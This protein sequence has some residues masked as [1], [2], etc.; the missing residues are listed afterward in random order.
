MEDPGVDP[1]GRVDE[2]RTVRGDLVAKK[3]VLRD[4]FI[5][6]FPELTFFFGG[7]PA[8]TDGPE[9]IRGP[10]QR[11][12]ETRSGDQNNKRKK[13]KRQVSVLENL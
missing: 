10:I 12:T 3:K 1:S 5:H 8:I 9:L 11:P 7:P 4:I 2:I 6:P 13:N